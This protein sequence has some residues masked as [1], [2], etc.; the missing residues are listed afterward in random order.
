[1]LNLTSYIVKIFQMREQ[2]KLIRVTRTNVKNTHDLNLNHRFC[3]SAMLPVLLA[4]WAP[5]LSKSVSLSL[6][7]IPRSKSGTQ[8]TCICT[9][10]P[11]QISWMLPIHSARDIQSSSII[12]RSY[13]SLR[14]GATITIV[15]NSL[16]PCSRMCRNRMENKCTIKTT[17]KTKEKK[18]Q[19]S[20]EEKV[21]L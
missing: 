15:R 14:S 21:C 2:F 5:N 12:P 13:C 1:M 18:N 19:L 16:I 8:V 9:V 6:E 7:L 4:H 3:H 11:L 17:L 20:R 10:L